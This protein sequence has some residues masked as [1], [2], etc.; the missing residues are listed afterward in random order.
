MKPGSRIVSFDFDMLD[1]IKPDKVIEGEAAFDDGSGKRSRKIYLWKT[2]F[3]KDQTRVSAAA[4]PSASEHTALSPQQVALKAIES[5]AEKGL[6]RRSIEIVVSTEGDTIRVLFRRPTSN[7]IAQG[8]RLPT[9]DV[10]QVTFKGKKVTTKVLDK[11]L[12][13]EPFDKKYTREQDKKF[14]QAVKA[15]LAHPVEGR[16][17]PRDRVC[18]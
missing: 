9:K 4:T 1:I 15:A 11:K 18:N 8:G 17:V 3:K 2:P 13:D 5:L 16:E 14:S 7:V 12:A 10:W 6:F